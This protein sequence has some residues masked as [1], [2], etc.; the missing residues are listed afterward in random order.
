VGCTTHDFW[1]PDTFSSI[2]EAGQAW[3]R[4]PMVEPLKE[5]YDEFE[6][7]KYIYDEME[8]NP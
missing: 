6:P 4:M 5:G 8:A 3:N 7:G 1:L 2:L